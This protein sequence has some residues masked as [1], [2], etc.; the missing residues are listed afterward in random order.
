MCRVLRIVL[1]SPT[2]P[3]LIMKSSLEK[4][5]IR[6]MYIKAAEIEHL[7]SY[8]HSA[9]MPTKTQAVSSAAAMM[10]ILNGYGSPEK[11]TS[12]FLSMTHSRH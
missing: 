7:T 12:T 9:W 6:G 2:N 3:A 11:W 5:G 8:W 10:T 4:W 1:V